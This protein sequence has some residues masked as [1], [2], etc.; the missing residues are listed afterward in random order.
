VAPFAE[1]PTRIRNVAHMRHKETDRV[2]AVVTEL[3]RLG[4]R[5]EEFDDGMAIFPGEMRPATIQ[6]YDDHRMAMSFAL[7]G[8]R[9]PGVRIADPQC[10]AKTYPHYFDDLRQL[11]EGRP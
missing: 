10:T 11:C 7:I 5:V 6:T 3:A 9:Q 8:L 2:H 4:L 1:G